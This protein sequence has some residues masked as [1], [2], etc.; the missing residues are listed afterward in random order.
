MNR[1]IKNDRGANRL[2]GEEDEED[3]TECFRACFVALLWMH[4][5]EKEVGITR[6]NLF[7]FYLIA[8][9]AYPRPRPLGVS[10]IEVF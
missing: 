9:I 2:Q 4:S 3:T 7:F 8:N 5:I 10:G 6:P 1:T